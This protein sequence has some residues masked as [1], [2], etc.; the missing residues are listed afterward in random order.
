MNHFT[1]FIAEFRES[2]KLVIKSSKNV[3][4][5]LDMNEKIENLLRDVKDK[6]N[7]KELPYKH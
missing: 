2:M 3:G 4:D 6:F 7:E 5:V 1:K